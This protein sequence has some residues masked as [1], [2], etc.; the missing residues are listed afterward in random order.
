MKRAC[1]MVK[2]ELVDK[3]QASGAKDREG[4]GCELGP[5]LFLRPPAPLL[6][7]TPSA[8]NTSRA[9]ASCHL[10]PPSLITPS[11]CILTRFLP[12]Q[13]THYSPHPASHKGLPLHHP[14]RAQARPRPI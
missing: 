13:P 7:H 6:P 2:I 3:Q 4:L 5:G 11:L 12:L 8:T 1:L 10:M 9:R 14:R